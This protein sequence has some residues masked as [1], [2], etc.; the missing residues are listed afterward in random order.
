MKVIDTKIEIIINGNSCKE[1]KEKLEFWIESIKEIEKE[2]SCNCT[3][4]VKIN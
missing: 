1:Q 4:D 3:L 2:H